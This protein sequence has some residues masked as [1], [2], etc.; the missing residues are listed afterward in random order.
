MLDQIEL[1]EVKITGGYFHEKQKINRQV[2]IPS[3]YA[4]FYSTGRIDAF[5]LKW[6]KGQPNQPHIFWDSDVAKWIEGA[7]YSLICKRDENL[8]SLID[9][10]VDDIVSGQTPEGYFN[11]YYQTVELS[12]RFTNRNNHELYC[13]GHLIEGAVAY[14]KATGKDA[15]LGAMCRYA[16]YINDV[17]TDPARNKNYV[18]PGHEEI[19]LALVKLYSE[20]KKQKYLYLSKFFIDMRG[21]LDDEK[22]T[23]GE[24][25]SEHYA[26]DHLPIAEQATAEGHS[27][28]CLYMFSGAADIAKQFGDE[29]LKKACETVFENIVNKRMYVTGGIGGNY[30]GEAFSCDYDLPN[31]LAYT[32]TCASI[33]MVFFCQRMFLLTGEKKYIDVA[34]LQI[35]NTVMAGLSLHGDRFFYCNPL[36]VHPDRRDYFAS[37]RNSQFA[38]EYERPEYFACSC[39]PPNVIRLISSFG[40]Y[41]YHIDENEKNDKIYVNL[42]NNSEFCR[43][44]VKIVQETDYP[45]NGKIEIKVF[46]KRPVNILLRKPGWCKSYKFENNG[47]PYETDEEGYI[48][49][50]IGQSG[51]YEFS[52]DLEMPV[53]E[54]YANPKV[55]YCA[56]RVAVK[57][58]PV[59]Y[60][61]EGIDNG[62][63]LKSAAISKEPGY[64]CEK[65]QIEGNNMIKISCEGAS[66]SQKSK[67]DAL[68]SEKPFKKE[69]KL[70]ELIP[71]AAWSNRG[72]TEMLVWIMKENL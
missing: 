28:R 65:F 68:Y 59:V 33:A 62:E 1:C 70:L 41:M 30:S 67:A 3:T 12:N 44:G 48:N 40:Q 55:H 5:K 9:S 37:I 34:E 58:G 60:C 6:Q 14:K 43:N 18:T 24:W 42:Y 56:G 23:F 17:F 45:A 16:D 13:A 11:S 53:T 66:I 32:E 20:T 71:Y 27:V 21:T 25:A 22:K 57:R 49:V 31:E 72:R 7:A 39:C 54:L 50:A 61:A 47:L 10:I 19:E 15:F 51:E 38:P 29:K 4:Q 64:R 8:E 36:E 46:A 63:N 52:L 26:Q 69:K 2:T 35:Y